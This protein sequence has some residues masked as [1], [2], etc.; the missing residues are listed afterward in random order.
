MMPAA[1]NEYLNITLTAKEG[2]ATQTLLEKAQTIENIVGKLSE[3]KNYTY[4]IQDNIANLDLRI[5]P[6]K[7]RKR[8]SF[9]IEHDLENQLSSLK[10]KDLDV[11]IGIKKN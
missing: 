9:A 2:I 4:T 7:A 3:L 5:V 6:R 8:D 11:E 1:D 10:T